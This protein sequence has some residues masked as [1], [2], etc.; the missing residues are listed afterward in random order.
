[1]NDTNII[2]V[3]LLVTIMHQSSALF[4][5]PTEVNLNIGFEMIRWLFDYQN[6]LSEHMQIR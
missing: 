2:I 4:F 6:I 3:V 1:M 5:G